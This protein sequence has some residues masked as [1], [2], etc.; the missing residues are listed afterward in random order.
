MIS[1]QKQNEIIEA[2]GMLVEKKIIERAKRARLFQFF[3]MK[4]WI[5]VQYNR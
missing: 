4:L 2:I 5:K 1:Q 3:V